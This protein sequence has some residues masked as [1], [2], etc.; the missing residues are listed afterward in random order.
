V[1]ASYLTINFTRSADSM[2]IGRYWGAGPL[3][4]YSRAMNLL[5]LP[6]RQLGAPAR[7]V[8]VPAFSRVQDDPD[9]LARVYL[10]MANL[11][12][13]ITGPIF[14]FLFVASTPVIV[15]TLGSKWRTAG[16]VF[17]VLAIFALGQLLYESSVWL[18]ISRGLSRRL[19]KIS[20]IVCP[21]TVLGYAAGLPFGIKGVAWSGALVMLATF[22]WMLNLSFRGTPLT[23]HRLGK[24]L[25][26]PVTTTL[27]GVAAGELALHLVIP[28][29][30]ISQILVGGAGFAAGCA[31][32]LLLEPVRQE[33][34][35]L[36]E[37][38]RVA[39]LGSPTPL[40]ESLD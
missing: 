25:V 37:L 38:L 21:V 8:A 20:L 31:V 33:V 39:G 16:P 10:R 3:G 22:P 19:L 36:R 18:L 26:F 17:Q 12:M 35:A 29:S 9:R 7:R 32:M 11:I 15:L 1:A 27:L 5:L 34:T 23:L 2:L 6:T 24:R 30:T 40:V 28:A 13:W 4:L 14:G